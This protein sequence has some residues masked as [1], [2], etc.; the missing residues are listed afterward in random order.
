MI[1]LTTGGVALR[2][3]RGDCDTRR[4]TA[5]LSKD[6]GVSWRATRVPL[7][8]L[9][10]VSV[11][12]ATNAWVI[13]LNDRCSPTL[14]RT[15]DGGRTWVRTNTRGTW[16]VLPGPRSRRLHAG[17]GSVASPCP[18]GALD[19][20]A[21]AGFSAAVAVCGDGRLHGTRDGGRSWQRRGRV[22]RG[23][24]VSFDG[25]RGFAAAQSPGCAGV[26]VLASTDG[27]RSWRRRGCVK[28]AM[29][30][31]AVAF[32]D[33]TRGLLLAGDQSYATK[34]AGRSWARRNPPA[35]TSRGVSSFSRTGPS[36]GGR[37][38]QPADTSPRREAHPGR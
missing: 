20:L 8:A 35:G 16:H 17:D 2:A 11:T 23:A 3:H 37:H 14:A 6:G 36:R 5:E 1:D 28:G 12:S 7:R 38:G 34:D 10:R 13:G 15:R 4:A 19:H 9:L 24:Q 18:P 30:P 21:V 29:P 22:P 33:P 32:S 26:T 27:G 25:G 31:A